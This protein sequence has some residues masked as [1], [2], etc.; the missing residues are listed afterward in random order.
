MNR[1]LMLRCSECGGKHPSREM[2]K[3]VSGTL[4]LLGAREECARA[5]NVANNAKKNARE[6][7]ERLL[8]ERR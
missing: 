7:H 3:W 5:A 1:P 8:R 6:K 4:V 2:Q